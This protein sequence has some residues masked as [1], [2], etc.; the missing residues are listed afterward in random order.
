MNP[1]STTSKSPVPTPAPSIRS[2]TGIIAKPPALTLRTA[3]AEEISTRA[4]GLWKKNGSPDGRDMEFWF[5][6]ERQLGL[7]GGR[8]TTEEDNFADKDVIFD[9]NNEANS[10]VDREIK[11]EAESPARRSATSL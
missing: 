6:A 5:E 9:E 7:G 1:K 11:G 4:R 3:T 8:R 10:P 2:S